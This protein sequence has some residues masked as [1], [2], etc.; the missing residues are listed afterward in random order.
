MNAAERLKL[1]DEALS[2]CKKSRFYKVPE[3]TEHRARAIRKIA[4]IDPPVPVNQLAEFR[5]LLD[6][7]SDRDFHTCLQVARLARKNR[8]ELIN[9]GDRSPV[10]QEIINQIVAERIERQSA[11]AAA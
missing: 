4:E 3:R 1:A 8:I 10:M 2:L 11:E 6:M 9:M 7:A 5:R